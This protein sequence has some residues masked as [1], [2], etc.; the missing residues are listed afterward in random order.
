V[1]TADQECARSLIVEL[2][3]YHGRVLVVDRTTAA[4]SA[5]HGS[6]L[7]GLIHGGPGRAGGSEELGGLRAVLHH[8]QRVAVQAAPRTLAVWPRV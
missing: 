2:A 3:P 1:F 5:G 6:P 8:M 7:P 4:H